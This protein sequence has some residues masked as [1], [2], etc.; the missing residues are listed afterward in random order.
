MAT[1]DDRTKATAP[2]PT[3]DS[4]VPAE[5]TSFKHLVLGNPN[6]F[7]TFTKF[8]GKVIKPFSGNTT[9]E[10]LAC[11]G[12]NPGPA[13]LEAVVNIKQ[14]SGYGTD[15]CGPGS[16]EYVRFFV[17]D[18]SGWH[19]LGL[20]KV[21][22]YD[23]SGVLPLSYSV[24]VP[25]TEARKFCTTE[26]IV[27]VRAILSWEWE[28]TPGDP[29]FIPVWGNVVNARVQVAP[30]LL[31]EV[32][33]ADLIAQKALSI[34]PGIL[35]DVNVSQALPALPQ[36]P[37]GYGA[38]KALYANTKVP[39]PSLRLQRC[40][41]ARER[42]DHP[43][44]A[45]PCGNGSDERPAADRPQRRSPWCPRASWR[46]TNCP[47]FWSVLRRPSATPPTS[48]SPAPGTTRRPARWKA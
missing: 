41:K 24:S 11:L 23:V 47:R 27:H 1:Q 18:T 7:G 42:I 5:R 28:P 4:K 16:T 35:K 37:L 33:I 8:P 25:F 12:L 38:L 14:H 46:A 44:T 6:Y 29:N 3:A 21:N 48:S 15:A 2:A 36:K 30:R 45:R 13:I 17:Q 34:D 20:S 22:V 19:D 39:T 26:N 40:G 31:F 9:F 10:E 32:A 43:S